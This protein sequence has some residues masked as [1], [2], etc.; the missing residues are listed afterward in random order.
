M[1]TIQQC[2]ILLFFSGPH[3][4]AFTINNHG[5]CY[6]GVWDPIVR[7]LCRCQ[8]GIFRQVS[9]FINTDTP[10]ITEYTIWK[11]FMWPNVTSHNKR[12]R[13]LCLFWK[14]WDICSF[15]EIIKQAFQWYQTF[16]KWSPTFEDMIKSWCIFLIIFF[17]FYKLFCSI[18]QNKSCRHKVPFVVNV[19]RHK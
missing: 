9:V 10:Q 5:R 14:F 19:M 2:L 3:S 17:I 18:S 16:T 6:C 12:Y 15:V 11:V 4:V 13:T 8:Q 7:F 1:F